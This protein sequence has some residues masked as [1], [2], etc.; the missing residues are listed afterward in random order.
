MTEDRT[1]PETRSGHAEHA[2]LHTPEAIRARLHS[3]PDHNYLRD[4]IYGAI[5]GAVTTFAVV[6]GVAG[7]ELSTGIVIVLGVANLVGDGFSMAAGNFLGTRAEQQL[8]ARARLREEREI[9]LYPDGERE[10]IRQILRRKGFDGDALEPAVEII[11]SDKKQWVDMMMTDELGLPLHGPDPLRA[12]CTT[13]VAFLLIGLIPLLPFINESLELF[14]L[15]AP[16]LWSSLLTGAAFLGIGVGKSRF[17][18]Q[19]WYWS[20][21][22][23]LLIGGSAATLAYLAGALLKGLA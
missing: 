1:T 21:L 16:F 12:A 19:A 10:E 13:F 22:E 9:E 5:D 20:G 18:E 23:T 8:R 4:F 6:S 14:P 11:T 3:D 15:S 7:A 17:V 2:A